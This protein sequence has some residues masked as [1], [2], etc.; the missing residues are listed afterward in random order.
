MNNKHKGRI[1][2]TII[3]VFS[4]AIKCV[5]FLLVVLTFINEFLI[6]SIFTADGAPAYSRL[7]DYN[8]YLI[9]LA[10]IFVSCF[11]YFSFGLIRKRG[12]LGVDLL[13]SVMIVVY[14]FINFEPWVANIESTTDGYS[15]LL[16]NIK[17]IFYLVLLAMTLVYMIVVCTAALYHFFFN[18]ETITP[19]ASESV[20]EVKINDKK[21]KMLEEIQQRMKSLEDSHNSIQE[22]HSGIRDLY[23]EKLKLPEG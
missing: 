19:F 17:V 22:Y 16:V 6:Y 11:A 9:A 20:Y 5:L 12:L 7:S 15:S 4:G 10:A 18:V 1:I 3:S 14:I 23:I 2:N 21:Y 13:L 8:D